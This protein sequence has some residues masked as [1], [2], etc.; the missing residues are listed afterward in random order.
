[1]TIVPIA[2][3]IVVKVD[4]YVCTGVECKCSSFG[5]HVAGKINLGSFFTAGHGDFIWHH[6]PLHMSNFRA[7]PLTIAQD[8][9]AHW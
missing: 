4:V 2:N 7:C 6:R 5:G 9:R 3:L 8:I 1:M